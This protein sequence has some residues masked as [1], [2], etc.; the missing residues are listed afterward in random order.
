VNP[1]HLV[2]PSVVINASTST[3]LAVVVRV[4]A[5]P[6]AQSTAAG[7]VAVREPVPS[8]FKTSVK[9]LAVP[10]AGGFEKVK[11]RLP[12]IVISNTL[13]SSRLRVVVPVPVVS[14]SP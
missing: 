12:S 9:L 7:H 6:P 11:E 2:P 10:E 3:A 5:V 4:G 1:Y 14:V 13:P 8:C